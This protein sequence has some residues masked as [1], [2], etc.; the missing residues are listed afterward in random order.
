MEN[1]YVMHDSHLTKYRTPF[2]AVGM[3]KE[4]TICIEAEKCSQVFLEVE[5]FDGSRKNIEM[6]KYYQR[7]ENTIIYKTILNTGN[8]L[9]LIHYYFRLIYSGNIIYYGNNIQRFGGVGA[10]YEYIPIPYQIT[11]YKEFKVPQWYKQ[12]V[13]YQIFVDRFYKGKDGVVLNPKRN[14]FI[15]GTWDDEPMYIKDIH[16]KIDRWDFYGGNLIGVIEKLPYIKSLG[17]SIIY[18][19]PIFEAASNHKYDIGDYKSIDSMFGE[20]NVFKEL[21]EKA[22]KLGIKVV[23]DGVFSHTGSDSIYFNKMGNYDSLGAFQS[24][25][26]SYYSW[27]KFKHYPYDYESWWGFDNLPNVEEMNPAYRNFIITDYDSVIRK[28]MSLG[29]FGWRL[30]VA[31]ELPDDFIKELKSEMKKINEESVL[32]GEVWEDAS[33]KVSYGIKRSYFFG[34]ELDSVTNYP[35][36][37][38]IIS[39]LLNYINSYEVVRRLMSLKENYPKENFYS[40][41]N[42]LGNHDTE[43]IYTVLNKRFGEK[44]KTFK[45]LK[46]AIFFQMTFPG[47]PLI[48]YGDEAGVKGGKDPQNRRTYPWGREDVDIINL[49]KR[50]VYIRNINEELIYGDID[51]INI[52]RDILV[53]ERK[54]KSNRMF[55]FI[56]RNEQETFKVNLSKVYGS[57]INLDNEDEIISCSGSLN[58]S[59]NPFEIKIL[60]QKL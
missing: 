57:F 52:C 20:D 37:D 47:V 18:F 3:Q 48:Y 35:V 53:Y 30:D 16:G 50:A 11:V 1:I 51:F 26:S 28:W 22:E 25:D 24:K 14:S 41:M 19:N 45:L 59:I 13:V 23:L 17:V 54:Y 40:T 12:G 5:F 6:E 15:Y 56:N 31:D 29:A 60:K 46:L 44:E 8:N 21:C 58:T 38:T 49:Y 32:I 9:G 36:R 4:I 10:I 55:I 42:L 33:N 39:F 34:E 7:K 43:R 27:Y 2:G